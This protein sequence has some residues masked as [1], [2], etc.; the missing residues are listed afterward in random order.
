MPQGLG[1]ISRKISISPFYNRNWDRIFERDSKIL[2]K[3]PSPQ[4]IKLRTFRVCDWDRIFEK[5][6]K[7][8]RFVRLQWKDEQD[9][10][11]GQKF[12]GWPQNF[13][14]GLPYKSGMPLKFNRQASDSKK[15]VKP[16]M[17]W[18]GSDFFEILFLKKFLASL[19]SFPFIFHL[20]WH[21]IFSSDWW[22][23]RRRKLSPKP[24]ILLKARS[25]SY[26]YAKMLVNVFVYF[27]PFPNTWNLQSA[28]PDSK[29]DQKGI[30]A[31]IS[32][33]L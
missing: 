1:H 10:K 15:L 23:R 5:I 13:V 30:L 20:F 18:L 4:R 25:I 11:L 6:S 33:F 24:V 22:I 9:T 19:K 21:K 2:Q 14:M 27:K 28:W 16:D 26:L 31:K 12:W 8:P 32:R 3:E 7:I 17:T 29:V